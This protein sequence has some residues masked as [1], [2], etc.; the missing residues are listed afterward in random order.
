MKEQ[1]MREAIVLGADA[2]NSLSGKQVAVFGLGGVGGYAVEALARAGVGALW[3]I[4]GDKLTITNL[5]RQILALSS[6]VGLYKTEVAKNRVL[7]INPDCNVKITTEFFTPKNANDFDFSNV[8][9]II[10]AIDT[11]KCKTELIAKAYAENIPIISAMGAGNKVDPT[12]FKVADIYKTDVCPLAKIMRHELRKRNIKKLKT[13]YSPELPVTPDTDALA[14]TK[15]IDGGRV[16]GSTSFVP[17]V[18]GLI[19]AGEVIKDLTKGAI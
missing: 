12:A 6:T 11:V 7:D 13:V 14:V 19:M 10:D 15:D 4:D 18:M 16:A 1:F 2:V 5:N 3:L 9:Y 8:D 17:P